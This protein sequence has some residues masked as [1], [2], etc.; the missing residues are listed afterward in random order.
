M[1]EEYFYA[2]IAVEQGQLEKADKGA[3]AQVWK[4]ESLEAGLLG[5][6]TQV[7]NLHTGDALAGER[8]S[9][10]HPIRSP[11]EGFIESHKFDPTLWKLNRL[12]SGD[13]REMFF[14]FFFFAL[15]FIF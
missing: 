2:Q 7:Q 15:V 4:L 10:D 9:Q 5:F 1:T 11:H 14:F 13:E 8:Y 12:G 3:G 6:S